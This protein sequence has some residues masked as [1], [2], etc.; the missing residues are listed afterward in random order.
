MNKLNY[1]LSLTSGY[2]FAEKRDK[3]LKF[4]LFLEELYY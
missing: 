1:R 4:W 3:Y 2:Y